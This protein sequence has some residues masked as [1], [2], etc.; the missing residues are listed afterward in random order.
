M[1]A[2]LRDLPEPVVTFATYD[3]L[4]AACARREGGTATDAD[5]AS[6]VISYIT[7]SFASLSCARLLV[8]TR[9]VAPP[10]PF[11]P[12]ASPWLP[13]VGGW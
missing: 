4:M 2:L 9:T 3:A 8:L 1:Q 7:D 5:W 6:E 11:L 10:P 13:W 12:R